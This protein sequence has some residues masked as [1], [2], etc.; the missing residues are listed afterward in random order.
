MVSQKIKTLK[1]D[2]LH[3]SIKGC[4]TNNFT[5]EICIEVT[6]HIF[7]WGL[8]YIWAKLFTNNA[9]HKIYWVITT[10]LHVVS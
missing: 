10:K 7:C 3:S 6:K 2:S 5:I 8:L 1:F 4:F 9:S